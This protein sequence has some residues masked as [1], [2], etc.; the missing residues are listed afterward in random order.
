MNTMSM[1]S[2]NVSC[3]NNISQTVHRAEKACAMPPVWLLRSWK[4]TLSMYSLWP[5]LV[6]ILST[7]LCLLIWCWCLLDPINFI[8]CTVVFD[9]VGQLGWRG[10]NHRLWTS[11]LNK[12]YTATLRDFGHTSHFCRKVPMELRCE[13]CGLQNHDTA[14]RSFFHPMRRTFQIND[15]TLLMQMDSFSDSLIMGFETV[16]SIHISIYGV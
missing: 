6:G 3:C 4:H 1:Y 11:Q 15:F 5:L 8:Y 16:I 9:F 10:S 14:V 12:Q 13:H 2:L 7:A